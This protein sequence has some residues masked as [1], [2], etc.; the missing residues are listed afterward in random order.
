MD[1][2]MSSPRTL[3]NAV[4]RLRDAG[5]SDASEGNRGEEHPEHVL[6]VSTHDVGCRMQV[7]WIVT[8]EDPGCRP[9]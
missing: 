1:F 9:L 6:S 5:Y 7:E 3:Q 8:I 2:V 4:H